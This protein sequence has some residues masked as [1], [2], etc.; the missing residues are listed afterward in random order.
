MQSGSVYT[1]SSNKNEKQDDGSWKQVDG[2]GFKLFGFC[3][4]KF[5]VKQAE[6]L[7]AGKSVTLRG[8]KSKAGKTFDCKVKLTRE[9]NVEPEFGGKGRCRK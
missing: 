5:T 4:K 2:C 1:C 7:L 9:G 6:N 3:N 8:C